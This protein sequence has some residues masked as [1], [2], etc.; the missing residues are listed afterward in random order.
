MLHVDLPGETK[1]GVAHQVSRLAQT[2]VE[3]GHEVTV[4]SLSP[5]PRGAAY[6]VHRISLPARLRRSRTARFVTVPLAY[7]LRSYGQFDVV[8]A[9]GD[10]HLLLRRR[11]AVVRTF[12]GSAREEARSARRLRRKALQTALVGG[13]H[14]ARRLATVA[15]GISE[16]TCRSIG[17]LD[18]VI[19]CG[20]DRRLFRPGEKSERPSILFV[21]TM[22]GRKRG[23]AVVHAF[24]TTVRRAIPS[25][26]L[27]LVAD[28][29]VEGEAIRSWG[30]VDDATLAGLY[31]R[32]WAFTMP[33]SYEGF[34]VPYLE[35]MAS[36]TPVVATP[37][38][39]A[40]EF[41]RPD[42]G[43]LV[44][45][46]TMLGACLASLLRR[47]AERARLGANGRAF[48]RRFDWPQI[49]AAYEDMYELARARVRRSSQ[50]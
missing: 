50:R 29:S 25:A 37:N 49:A 18:A 14:L 9:H 33:S 31:R 36:G 19:P 35:A 21:G 6:S 2:L 11:S 10:S 20:V 12:H 40:I 34:G 39:G 42:T 5:A 22:N 17:G 43:G 44:V 45:D 41:V 15:V 8:H 28:R 27:W 13:E 30:L 1:G 47:P 26:E 3:R 32:A 38:A 46:E 48:S 23:E 7:A 16:N 24:S 4:I